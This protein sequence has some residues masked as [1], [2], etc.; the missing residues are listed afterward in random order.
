MKSSDSAFGV[1]LF[2][3]CIYQSIFVFLFLYSIYLLFPKWAN[4]SRSPLSIKFPTRTLPPTF[5]GFKVV[6]RSLVF[7]CASPSLCTFFSNF[8]SFFQSGFPCLDELIIIWLFISSLYS[9]MSIVN[10]GFLANSKKYGLNP[11]TLYLVRL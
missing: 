3:Y 1:V 8:E 5:K 10:L 2:N 7:R 9:I 4:F 11:G 6:F